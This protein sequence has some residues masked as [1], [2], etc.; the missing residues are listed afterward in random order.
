MADEPADE[1]SDTGISPEQIAEQE[2]AWAEIRKKGLPPVDPE[3]FAKHREIEAD[4]YV[5]EAGNV[6]DWRKEL[7]D[8]ED[9]EDDVSEDR[10]ER[11]RDVL[12][13]DPDELFADEPPDEDD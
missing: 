12:G 3:L 11:V 7:P 13:F 9:D 5:G 10:L 2:S 4:V 8:D 1:G 6:P